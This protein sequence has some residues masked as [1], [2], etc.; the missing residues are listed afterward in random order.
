MSI[1]KTT[2]ERMRNAEIVFVVISLSTLTQVHWV[3]AMKYWSLS[4][5][6][7]LIQS[8][9][10]TD[11]MTRTFNIIFFSVAALQIASCITGSWVFITDYQMGG[12]KKRWLEI[13]AFLLTFLLPIPCLFLLDAFRRMGKVKSPDTIISTKTVVLHSF[14]YL[15]FIISLILVTYPKYEPD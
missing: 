11:H 10:N 5:K 14:A 8:G 3:F 13:T 12:N 7:Q 9:R 2:M 4:Y 6:L 15:T 1:S